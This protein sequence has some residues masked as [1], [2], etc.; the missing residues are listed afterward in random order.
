MK[1]PVGTRKN[2]HKPT[3][4]R[5][6][7]KPGSVL[8]LLAGRFRGMR[9]VFLKQLSSGLLLV[10]G[11]YAVN[12]VPLRRVDQRYVITTSTKVDISKADVSKVEDAFFK[13]ESTDADDEL[14]EDAAEPKKK[15]LPENKIAMQKSVDAALV[16]AVEKVPFLKEYLKSKFTLAKGL[17]PHQMKF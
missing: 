4:L 1:K 8:I 5:P 17:H 6:S 14:M 2:I 3:R 12:G 10:T 9:V 16:P 11:P 15:P 13:R 7:I